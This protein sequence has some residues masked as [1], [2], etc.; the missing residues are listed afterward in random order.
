MLL[1][2]V[3]ISTLSSS[4][5]LGDHQHLPHPDHHAGHG[6][7]PNLFPIVMPAM[8]SA[9][10][11]VYSLIQNGME[12]LPNTWESRPNLRYPYYDNKGKGYLLYGYGGKELYEYSEFEYLEGWY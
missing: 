3:L 2:A 10:V 9:E 1:T 7:S 6:V 11:G 8:D 4:L 5:L 12:S